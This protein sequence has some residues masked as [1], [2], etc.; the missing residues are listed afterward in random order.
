M[1]GEGDCLQIFVCFDFT[2]NDFLFWFVYLFPLHGSLLYQG[3]LSLFQ[4]ESIIP[5]NIGFIFKINKF[6]KCDFLIKLSMS[7]LK[8]CHTKKIKFGENYF[9]LNLHQFNKLQEILIFL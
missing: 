5:N 4:C 3:L 7:S 2:T 6:D 1:L 8:K 9:Y